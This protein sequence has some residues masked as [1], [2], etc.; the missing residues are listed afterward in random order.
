QVQRRTRQRRM[1]LEQRARTLEAR[2]PRVRFGW[3]VQRDSCGIVRVAVAQFNLAL[4]LLCSSGF[5]ISLLL[6]RNEF[7]PTTKPSFCFQH[8]PCAARTSGTR[9]LP[10]PPLRSGGGRARRRAGGGTST[11]HS[12]PDVR[13]GTSSRDQM[14][15]AILT[16]RRAPTLHPPPLRF[17]SQG[18]G[19]VIQIDASPV[20]RV[21]PV[22]FIRSE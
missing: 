18:R 17:A 12:L 8:L 4:A 14:F 22:S 10:T 6:G 5:N 16:R 2:R 20:G 15:G 1:P 21:Q 9:L 19:R 3:Y 13:D 11:R 7:R